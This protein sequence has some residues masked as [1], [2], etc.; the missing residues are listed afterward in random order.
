[1]NRQSLQDE[2]GLMGSYPPVVASMEASEEPPDAFAVLQHFRDARGELDVVID[3]I[4]NVEGRV[5]GTRQ[6]ERR[7]GSEAERITRVSRETMARVG[8]RQA[9]LRGV[10]AR[11]RK[12]AAALR[13]VV[14]RDTTFYKDLRA[15]QGFWKVHLNPGSVECPFSIDLALA[16]EPH[17]AHSDAAAAAAAPDSSNTYISSSFSPLVP[18]MRDPS[19]DIRVQVEDAAAE[20]HTSSAQSG[21]SGGSDTCQSPPNPTADNASRPKQEETADRPWNL[22]GRERKGNLRCAVGIQEVQS[23]LVGLHQARMWR[24]IGVGLVSEAVSTS[25]NSA[26]LGALAHLVVQA[27]QDSQEPQLASLR[28]L[29]LQH[30]LHCRLPSQTSSPHLH[31]EAP[32]NGSH[33]LADISAFLCHS[34]YRQQQWQCLDAESIGTSLISMELPPNR[35]LLVVVRDTKTEVEGVVRLDTATRWARDTTL[36]VGRHDTPYVLAKVLKGI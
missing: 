33:L 25:G 27:A 23:M 3:L 6:Y 15:L 7:S 34:F 12:D 20:P 22:L 4:N 8:L 16:D 14:A 2:G 36:S 9:A 1:M 13:A 21:R 35:R 30:H 31:L 24:H 29:L 32:R 5:M 17:F 11:L 28:P 18:L 26:F 19:G 10:A